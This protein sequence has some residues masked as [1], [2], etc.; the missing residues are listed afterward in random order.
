MSYEIINR[1]RGT[2]IIRIVDSGVVSINLSQLSANVGTENVYQA[3]ISSLRWS[4]PSTGN[5]TI[6]RQNAGSPSNTIAVLSETGYWPHDD[7][8]LAN[9]ATGNIQATFLGG[10]GTLIMVVKKDANYNVQTQDL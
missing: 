1:L 9:S 10:T 2:S 3:Q 5:V 6:A 7:F 8:N 4:T